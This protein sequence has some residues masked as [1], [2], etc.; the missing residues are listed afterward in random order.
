MTATKK[1]SPKKSSA[2]PA[3]I[4]PAVRFRW[5]SLRS[6]RCLLSQDQS[7]SGG[8]RTGAREPGHLARLPRPRSDLLGLAE[9]DQAVGNPQADREDAQRPERDSP[10]R[11]QGPERAEGGGDDP[12]H[13]AIRSAAE[14]R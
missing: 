7:A 3:A 5:A 9:H 6:I 1:L 10:D 14:Q 11:Q 12:N 4:S 13:A 8:W 2:N